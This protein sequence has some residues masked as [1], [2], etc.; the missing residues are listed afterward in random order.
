MLCQVQDGDTATPTGQRPKMVERYTTMKKSE[1][2]DG[3]EL[4]EKRFQPERP[5]HERASDEVL[6]ERGGDEQASERRRRDEVR[7]RES[8]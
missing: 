4:E 8:K 5:L 7:D 1:R 2:L 3:K 6:A